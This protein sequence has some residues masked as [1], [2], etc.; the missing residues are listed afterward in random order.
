ML[1]GHHWNV[2]GVAWSPDGRWLASS[3]WDNAVRVWDATTGSEVR[4]LQRALSRSTPPS[5]VWRGVP[6]ESLLA[7]GSYQQ[8][9]QVWEMSTGARR[10]VGHAQPARI[11]RVVWS[12]D[13][14]RLASGGED[15]SVCLWD[16]SDG[17]LLQQLQGHR[18]VVMS[19]AWS[20]DGTRLASGG[21]GRGGGGEIFVWEVSSGQCLAGLERAGRDRVCAGLESGGAAQRRRRWKY[22]LVGRAER[23]CVTIRQGHQ[24]AI[25]S[26]SVSPDGGLV[27]SCGDDGAINIWDIE[28]GEYL[29]TLRSDRPYERL[30]ISG[31]KG[32]TEAQRT[33]LRLLGAVERAPSPDIQQMIC[34]P[35]LRCPTQPRRFLQHAVQRARSHRPRSSECRRRSPLAAGTGAWACSSLQKA[36]IS[37]AVA[38]A[39]GL[40]VTKALIAWPRYASGT[41]ITAASAIAGWSSRP[42]STSIGVTS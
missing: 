20:P 37:F 9:V 21:S 14:T 42:C 19:I 17:R 18:G 25:Q 29:R 13:G 30:D 41:P 23:E 4:S 24:G 15:G 2:Y 22:A 39:P 38:A 28:S 33:T 3:G 32:L 34:N 26:M 16:A 31:V 7:S 8:G 35:K 10:W 5:M 6:M 40:S 27:A 11:R 1:R 12:P 36:M